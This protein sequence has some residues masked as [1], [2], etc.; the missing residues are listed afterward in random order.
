MTREQIN[1]FLQDCIVSVVPDLS[2]DQL[3]SDASLRR[4][5]VDS[6]DRS[7]IASTMRRELGIDISAL[8]LGKAGDLREIVEL[9]HTRIRIR[10]SLDQGVI[11]LKDGA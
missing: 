10:L 8:E 5:G 4:L 7:D 1:V 6:I 2:R 9:L 3:A 11:G